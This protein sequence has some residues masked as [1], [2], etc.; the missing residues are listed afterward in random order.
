LA[1]EKW[2]LGRIHLIIQKMDTIFNFQKFS[3]RD[4][5][6]YK[7]WFKDKTLQKTLGYID[8]E[9]LDYILTDQTG[10]E[11][12]VFQNQQLIGVIGLNYPNETEK[13][14]VI[15]NIALQPNLKNR[16]LGSKMLKAFMQKITLKPEEYWVSYV[17]NFN[18]N[19]QHFFEKNGWTKI[20]EVDEMIRYEYHQK[21]HHQKTCKT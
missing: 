15:S 13:S 18:F 1:A 3:A 12:S 17:E 14:Y 10:I 7:A 5:K 21:S 2:G 11:Y 16:G 8:K 19:A 9:W 6:T 20:N 4:F